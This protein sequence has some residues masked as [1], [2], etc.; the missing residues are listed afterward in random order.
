MATE[1]TPG[2]LAKIVAK[3]Q[4]GGD[5]GAKAGLVAI[6]QAIETRAKMNA[7][8][9]SHRKG[10]PHVPGTGPGPNVVT[11]NLRRSI[12]HQPPE[13]D[14]SGWFV[15]IGVASTASYGQYVEKLYPFLEPAVTDMR[16]RISSLMKPGFTHWR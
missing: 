2:V 13:Q 5:E 11:G 1:L 4:Q 10:E 8:S 15:R 3:V 7:N 6:A 9:G 14:G 12:T 16:S